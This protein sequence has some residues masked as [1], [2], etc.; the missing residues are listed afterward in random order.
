[1]VSTRVTVHWG[2]RN[3]ESFEGLLDTG[4][5]L[6]LIPGKLECPSGPPFKT[7]VY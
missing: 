4:S 5:E 2:K 3:N 1:M 7:G 6:L